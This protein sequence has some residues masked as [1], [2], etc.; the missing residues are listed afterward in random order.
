MDIKSIKAVAF[1]AVGTLI[2]PIPAVTESYYL[3]GK[4]YG[5]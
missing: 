1:D 5:S 3:F 2:Y 4:K